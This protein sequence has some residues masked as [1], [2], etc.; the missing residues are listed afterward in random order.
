MLRCEI[1]ELRAWARAVL[2]CS[3]WVFGCSAV[4]P[5]LSTPVR[6]PPAGYRF[7]PEAPADILYVAF[8]RATIPA[9]TRDGREWDSVGGSLPDVV[10]KLVVDENDLVVTP[11]H[12]NSLQPT[13]PEQK[14][15]NYRISPKASVTV[16]L[17]DSN[18]INDRPIC[19]E[20]IRDLHDVARGEGR[21]EVSCESGAYVELEV[22]PARGTIGIGM[23]YELRTDE[24]F[25]TQVAPESPAARAQL[26]RGDEIVRIMGEPAKNMDEKRVRSLINANASTG[27]DLV[28]RSKGG[29]ER[30]ITLR[31]GPIYATLNR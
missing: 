14:R 8:T 3:V 17:W 1:M 12:A 13:W 11:V 6:Q 4:Y 7:Q 23:A 29:A 31:D 16:E 21:L 15:G 30:Q 10:A 5:E 18:P 25:V 20:R 22:T 2:G 9:R 19:L 27:L 24:V 26:A 28:V